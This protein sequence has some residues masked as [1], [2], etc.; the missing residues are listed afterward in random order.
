MDKTCTGGKTLIQEVS[1]VGDFKDESK[2]MKNKEERR[3]IGIWR[4]IQRTM[5]LCS[6]IS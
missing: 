2:E 5:F 4:I 6:Y 1:D 3:R